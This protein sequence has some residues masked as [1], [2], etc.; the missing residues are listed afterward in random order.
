M[1]LCIF[2]KLVDEIKN[3]LKSCKWS[4]LWHAYWHIC[5]TQWWQWKS[6][7]YTIIIWGKNHISTETRTS[8]HLLHQSNYVWFADFLFAIT[9]NKFW[10]FVQ[11]LSCLIKLYTCIC[12]FVCCI[13]YFWNLKASP[14]WQVVVR[15]KKNLL[16]HKVT[17]E[18]S[19]A[20]DWMILRF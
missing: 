1:I 11:I 16:W 8:V 20:S 2:L 9:E 4:K 6:I 12:L 7:G 13:W 19:K 18:I 15:E 5:V 3:I 14:R 17:S 10:G